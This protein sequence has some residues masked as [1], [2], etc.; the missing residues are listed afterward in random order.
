MSVSRL[1]RCCCSSFPHTQ[2][3]DSQGGERT[4]QFDLCI[5]TAPPSHSRKALMPKA[6]GEA[7]VP[8]SCSAV[9]GAATCKRVLYRNIASAR[10]ASPPLP[11]CSREKGKDPL[12]C[13]E[14][15]EWTPATA[16]TAPRREPG[17]SR[18]SRKGSSNKPSPTPPRVRRRPPALPSRP[19]TTAKS[20]TSSR[21]SKPSSIAALY[22]FTLSKRLRKACDD[23]PRS[24]RGDAGSV[25]RRRRS[26][27]EL[28]DCTVVRRVHS[29]PSKP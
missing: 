24:S 29:A 13:A 25:L 19:L 22:R 6:R 2:H 28:H 9:E 10:R 26:N 14:C 8:Y 20:W 15:A 4:P 27:L 23:G 16:T 18:L 3:T 7:P 11:L 1:P 12:E 21:V 17:P 5:G